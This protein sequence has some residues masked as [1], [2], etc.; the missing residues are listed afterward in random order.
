MNAELRPVLFGLIFSLSM[1]FLFI[2]AP[3]V[4]SAYRWP[5]YNGIMLMVVWNFFYFIPVLISSIFSGSVHY[6]NLFGFT[7]GAAIQSFFIAR[8]SRW[9]IG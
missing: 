4:D 1:V 2:F 7:I 8:A 6:F 5:E 3:V 9:F